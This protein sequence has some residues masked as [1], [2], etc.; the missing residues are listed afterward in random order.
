MWYSYNFR[1]AATESKHSGAKRYG[2]ITTSL[3]FENFPTWHQS[4]TINAFIFLKKSA[5]LSKSVVSGNVKS[6]IKTFNQMTVAHA[7]CI[8]Q[9]QPFLIAFSHFA[10][11]CNALC[12]GCI[13]QSCNS[14]HLSKK[15]SAVY[16]SQ[17]SFSAS[18][19][20][21]RFLLFLPP[22]FFLIIC[23]RFFFSSVWK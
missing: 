16:L 7:M 19:S 5:Y 15:K 21:K 2:E 22:F 8:V 11:K 18:K 20:V 17:L 12:L 10:S 3:R 6:S 1:F 23:V 13:R 9:T 14:L 4:Y